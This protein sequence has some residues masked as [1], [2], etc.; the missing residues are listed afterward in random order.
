MYRFLLKGAGLCGR[1]IQFRE[2]SADE[3]DEN[4]RTA[5][6]MLEENGTMMALQQLEVREGI[7]KCL[8]AVTKKGGIANT[9]E[10]LK[11]AESEW[12]KLDLGKLKMSDSPFAYDV[13]FRRAKDHIAL[14]KIW[15]QIH[16]PDQKDIDNIVEKIL[17]VATEDSIPATGSASGT[18]G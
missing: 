18:A 17:P 6:S 13:L 16:V 7:M 1:G 2:L 15:R 9:D 11:L 4:A 3:V 14:A 5:A 8:V 10:M 12:E